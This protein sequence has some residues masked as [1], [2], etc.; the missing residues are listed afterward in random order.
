[1]AHPTTGCYKTTKKNVVDKCVNLKIEDILMF[2]S[3]L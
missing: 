1:M 2:K 3:K